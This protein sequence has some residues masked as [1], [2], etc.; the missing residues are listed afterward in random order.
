MSTLEEHLRI[1]YEE[2]EKLETDSDR[3]LEGNTPA[4][5]MLQEAQASLTE[6]EEC[7]IQFEQRRMK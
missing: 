4:W 7:L 5:L 1:L 3:H 2:L 6:A